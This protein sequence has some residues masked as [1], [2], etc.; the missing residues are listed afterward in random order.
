MNHIIQAGS[1]VLSGSDGILESEI[2]GLI[3]MLAIKVHWEDRGTNG[4]RRSNEMSEVSLAIGELCPQESIHRVI[5]GAD[6]EVSEQHL[7]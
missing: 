1:G 7:Y 6:L 3:D 2:P 5:E 4:S